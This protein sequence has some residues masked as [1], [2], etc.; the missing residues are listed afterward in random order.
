MTNPY[1]LTYKFGSALDIGDAVAGGH[2]VRMSME[3]TIETDGNNEEKFAGDYG[4]KV[5]K[6]G[7]L[8]WEREIDENFIVP[9]RYQLI[10]FDGQSELFTLLFEGALVPYVRKDAK[11]TLEIKYYGD[12]DYTVEYIGFIDNTSI[13]YDSVEKKI[14]LIAFPKSDLLK[15]IYLY[16]RSDDGNFIGLNPLNLAYTNVDDVY[17]ADAVNVKTLLYKIFQYVNPSCT[18]SWQHHWEF[19]SYLQSIGY[20]P[21]IYKK[22][23]EINFNSN[24]LSA[25]FFSIDNL[26]Q[27]ETLYDLLMK[28]AFAFGFICGFIT[29]DKTFV[30]EIFYYDA[31]NIQTLGRVK[32][33]IISNKYGDVEAVR[34]KSRRYLRDTRAG[35]NVYSTDPYNEKYAIVPITSEMRGDNILDEEIPVFASAEYGSDY[36]DL[37]FTHNTMNFQVGYSRVPYISTKNYHHSMVANFYYN[38]RNR[39]KIIPTGG[40]TGSIGRV[41]SFIVQGIK[42]DYMKDFSYAGNGYQILSLKKYIDYNTA[43]IDALYITQIMEDNTPATGNEPPR[44]FTNVLPGGYLKDYSYNSEI[45]IANVNAGTATLFTIPAGFELKKIIIK[46][47]TKFNTLTNINISDND[48]ILISNDRINNEN[49]EVIES[50]QYKNYASQKTITATITKSGTCTAGDADIIFEVRTRL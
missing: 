40:G 27:I 31:S 11:I 38:I 6:W 13:Q 50:F 12:Q 30:K 47:N 32:K 10:L 3:F 19:S 23:D 44:P 39:S 15:N 37:E 22:L 49:N 21:T 8:A 7:T 28:Y 41:D 43:E 36:G 14:E 48:G 4:I 45:T 20:P 35:K 9:G 5:A 2:L 17:T 25:L 18:L 34:I 33:W 46:I 24:H 16:K 29:A 42:V 26:Y 1:T